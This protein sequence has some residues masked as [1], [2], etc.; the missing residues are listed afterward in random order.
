MAGRRHVSCVLLSQLFRRTGNPYHFV[1]PGILICEASNVSASYCIGQI[2]NGGVLAE[3][4]NPYLNFF[5]GFE[6]EPTLA[7]AAMAL[8]SGQG[9]RRQRKKDVQRR[10]GRSCVSYYKRAEDKV[11]ALLFR[12]WSLDRSCH[13]SA[14]GV[15]GL[16]VRFRRRRAAAWLSL[17]GAW[18]CLRCLLKLP[19]L[20]MLMV[21][22]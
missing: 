9:R 8:I 21:C 1:R 11:M 6:Y 14:A 13:E 16:Y 4:G 15:G 19:S 2:S 22:I 5:N 17:I 7:C 12:S 3:G 10:R 20:C 18:P